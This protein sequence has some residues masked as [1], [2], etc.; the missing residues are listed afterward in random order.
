MWEMV[1]CHKGGVTS[2]YAD[3]NYILTGG[4]DG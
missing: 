4:R 1:N 3:E 2:I